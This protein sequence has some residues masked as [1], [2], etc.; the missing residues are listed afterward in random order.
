M[1]LS[2]FLRS[3]S[4]AP[5]ARRASAFRDVEAARAASVER[6]ATVG[7]FAHGSIPLVSRAGRLFLFC[8]RGWGG[9]LVEAHAGDFRAAARTATSSTP[10]SNSS[11]SRSVS[12]RSRCRT[13]L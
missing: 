10:S 6:A 9:F 1:S 5:F 3:R 12:G 13:S 11:N 7:F 4:G 2:I 8:C